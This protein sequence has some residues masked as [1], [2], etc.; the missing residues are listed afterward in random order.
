MHIFIKIFNFFYSRF[1]L[2]HSSQK[3]LKFVGVNTN[4]NVY[5]YGGQPGMFGSEPWLITL[6]NNVYITAGCRFI[7]HDGGVL[8]LRH[9][10]PKLEITKP[11]IIGDN[12]Y[13]G[14]NSIILPGVKIGNNVIVGAGSIVTKDLPSDGVYAGS[15]ARFI[16]S[17]DE[18]YQ[19]CLENSLQLGHLPSKE[20]D[21]KLKELYQ[22][23]K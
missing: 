14:T 5:I 12:V 15:P 7:N 4:G 23:R 11:I 13:L 9:K 2:K 1:L 22:Y 19:K 8:V 10:E 6:G 21:T 18:Y 17:I 20:K 3:Y 16:K